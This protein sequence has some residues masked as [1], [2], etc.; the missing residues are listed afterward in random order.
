MP[1]IPNIL[2]I[3]RA[4]LC[5]ALLLLPLVLPEG[6]S[7]LGVAQ[8]TRGVEN[9]RKTPLP[10]VRLARQDFKA[11]AS[12][13]TK[14]YSD[15]FPFRDFMVRTWNV[16]SMAVFQEWPSEDV[17]QGL[18]GWFFFKSE[19]KDWLG[20][21]LYSPAVLADAQAVLVQR[22]D[23]LAKQGIAYLAVVAPNKESIYSE[24]LPLGIHKLSPI[25][26]LDQLAQAMR[27]AGIPFLDLRPTMMNAKAVNRAYSKTD[28]HWNSWGAFEG[29]RAIV[30]ALSQKFPAMKPLRAEDY[31]MTESTG[32]G[33]DLAGLLLMSGAI[34]ERFINMDPLVPYRAKATVPP[35]RV[36]PIICETDD[37]ALP[38]AL[39]F[40]DSFCISAWPF[41]AEHFSRSVFLWAPF[42]SAV[43]L[44]EKP[45]VVIDEV[46]E[47]DQNSLF[48][49]SKN[50]L[51]HAQKESLGIARVVHTLDSSG[52][53]QEFNTDRNRFY[54]TLYSGEGVK[55]YPNVNGGG[56]PV[57]MPT[58]D[59]KP[60][61]FT[62]RFRNTGGS[63]SKDIVLKV[64]YRNNGKDNNLKSWTQF[65][66]E[67]PVE[68]I[69]SIGPEVSNKHD[70]DDGDY[71]ERVVALR[72]ERPFTTLTVGF[73]I[74]CAQVNPHP[75]AWD[76][77]ET[78]FRRLVISMCPDDGP[79][80]MNE[81]AML[82]DFKL[83]GFNGLERDG[84]RLWRWAIG[85]MSSLSFSS[86]GNTV[87]R[88]TYSM[89]NPMKNQGY[90]LSI[91]GEQVSAEEGMPVQNWTK[92]TP[93]KVLQFTTKP[94][95]NT[96]SFQ[97]KKINHVNDSFTEADSSP[98]TMAFK[99]LRLEPVPSVRD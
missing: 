11:Y 38:K 59:K 87:M 18:D 41:L 30:E 86:A 15:N 53:Y 39:F 54:T 75:P 43:V 31:R 90:G 72:R 65:D 12:Q 60:A 34:Q 16:L 96:I 73:N 32:T 42:Q 77:R 25:T 97:F 82:S 85:P 3:L 76:M 28:T 88:L 10:P 80:L 35:E 48:G 66:A 93:V 92:A 14:A 5:V 69:Q 56:T 37:A 50:V 52:G 26:R 19:V 24:F 94:G 51:T 71:I 84:E 21:D 4:S 58:V 8:G 89:V 55:L 70:G 78:G 27:E 81:S 63:D 67:A 40:R 49:Y 46:L 29:S 62:Y 17:V 83:A 22:R 20:V 64:Q 36:K 23:W 47:R 61:E 79:F 99:I 6:L 57:A 9:R 45:D 33:G 44:A 7:L 1:R 13:L 2:S 91:N 95:R 74:S 98:Y 68:I